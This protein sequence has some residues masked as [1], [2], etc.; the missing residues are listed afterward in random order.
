[1]GAKDGK[2]LPE[3]Q[4]KERRE[5]RREVKGEEIIHEGKIRDNTKEKYCRVVFCSRGFQI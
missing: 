4:K 1:M 5:S 3:E 2:W